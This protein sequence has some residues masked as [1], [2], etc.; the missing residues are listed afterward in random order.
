M[1]YGL[2]VIMLLLSIGFVGGSVAVPVAVASMGIA[3]MMVGR[4]PTNEKRTRV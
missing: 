1:L 3:L 2:G 4:R